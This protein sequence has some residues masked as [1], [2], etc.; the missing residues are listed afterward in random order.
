MIKQ[1]REFPYLFINDL[2]MTNFGKDYFLDHLTND[3]MVDPSKGLAYYSDLYVQP[4][5]AICIYD[6][7]AY[8]L[9]F[10]KGFECLGLSDDEITMQ[11]VFET[12]IPAHREPCGE[13]SGNTLAF[14]KENNPTPNKDMITLNY[15]G[16]MA[17]GERVH[18]M[19]QA[20]IYE[21]DQKGDFISA[22]TIITK[23][24]H[25]KLPKV[26]LWQVSFESGADL[27]TTKINDT[28]TYSNRI[29]Q[30][31][32]Q[33]LERLAE[34]KTM[35][36]IG[37]DLFCSPRTVETHILNMRKRFDCQNTAQLVAFS[38]DLNLI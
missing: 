26:V 10:A 15:A 14:L 24:P 13:I 20:I 2:P 22:L 36:E 16:Q 32:I 1:I 35:Q 23:L 17:N 19:L 9:K 27:L 11:Q 7:Q 29:S 5:Q 3:P 4:N 34:G 12:A 28:L 18:L 6:Y 38:K 33:V 25:L 30:R 21:T 37:Y 31:E 8:E